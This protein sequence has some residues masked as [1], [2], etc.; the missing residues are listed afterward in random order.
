MSRSRLRSVG[1]CHIIAELG[2]GGMANV[3]LAVTHG[4]AGVKKLVVLKALRNE[5]ASE[6]EALAM[7]LDEARLAAQLNHPNVVQTYEIGVHGDRRVMVLEYLEGQPLSRVVRECQ[8]V[9]SPLP[10]AYALHITIAALEGLHYV[11]ELKSYDGKPLQLVHR[12]VSPQNVFV[13]YDGRVKLLDF[14]IAKATTSSTHTAIGT[15]KGKLA[16]MAPEQMSGTTIDRRADLYAVG[17]MLWAFATGEKLWQGVPDAQILGRVLK[18]DIPNLLEKRPDC[19]P[20]LARI[21]Q[22]AIAPDPDQRYPTALALQ[23]D[24]ERFCELR[25]LSVKQKDIG[26]LVSNLFAN[27][28]ARLQ[29]LI[30]SQLSLLDAAEEV[31]SV[32]VVDELSVPMSSIARATELSASASIREPAPEL[33]AHM[34]QGRFRGAR[35]L[36]L[37]ALLGAGLG[38]AWAALKAGNLGS[39]ERAAPSAALTPVEAVAAQTATQAQPAATP[40]APAQA[41]PAPTLA[42]VEFDVDP[43]GAKLFLDGTALPAG[44][45]RQALPP[46]GSKHTLRAELTGHQEAEVD[47]KVTGDMTVKLALSRVGSA[48]PR[49]AAPARRPPA[50]TRAPAETAAAPASAPAPAP[51]PPAPAPTPARDCSDP[52]FINAQG[53]K[54]VRPG[55]L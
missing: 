24:L 9:G 29:S 47:F 51:P 5:L 50:A 42:T 37:L 16:Y 55:C 38:G 54:Q 8:R 27:S 26:K 35:S 34:N 10:L 12:D 22:K 7:F 46:D 33:S 31:P 43:P 11:H 49:P 23:S 44:V 4:P 36:A 40:D 53:F 30:E 2:Q 13:T 17:C 41:A 52:F 45:R 25:G 3:Y 19:D 6:P 1:Q 28:R 20:E 15:M 48:R 39:A 21:V 18:G 14:G 32:H